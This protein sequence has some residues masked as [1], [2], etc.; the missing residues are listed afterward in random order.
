[1][2]C[3]DARLISAPGIGTYLKNI[4]R[5]LQSAPWKW[6]A[7]VQKENIDKLGPIEPI[8]VSSGIY[9]PKEQVELPIKIPKVD[10]FWSP[11]FNI[12]CLPIRARRRF[13]NVHDVFHLAHAAQFKLRER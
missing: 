13:V 6:C 2:I 12:P 3:V 11:H 5:E 9:S 1:M 4:L 10:L 8:V 7:L